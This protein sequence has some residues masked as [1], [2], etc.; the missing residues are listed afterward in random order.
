MNQTANQQAST[1][2][3]ERLSQSVIRQIQ[4]E[5]LK[6]SYNEHQADPLIRM[7]ENLLVME[8]IQLRNEFLWREIRYILALR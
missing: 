1:N 3:V 6:P 2:I 7:Q 8:E 4:E 5:S